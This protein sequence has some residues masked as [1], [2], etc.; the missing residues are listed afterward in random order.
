MRW[1]ANSYQQTDPGSKFTAH[2][3]PCR[4][5]SMSVYFAPYGRVVHAHCHR[6]AGWQVASGTVVYHH[7][8]G[9]GDKCQPAVVFPVKSEGRA[10]Y[11]LIQSASPLRGNRPWKALF[12]HCII[13]GCD[14]QFRLST[15]CL[16]LTHSHPRPLARR[17]VWACGSLPAA[18]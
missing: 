13:G 5:R 6:K 8:Y 10:S 16:V 9:S 12:L 4:P 7:G 14:R 2:I 3:Y 17:R 11:V 15:S 18:R 1:Q